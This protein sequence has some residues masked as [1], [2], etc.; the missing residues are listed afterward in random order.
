MVTRKRLTAGDDEA[1]FGSCEAGSVNGDRARLYP[2][3]C[4]WLEDVQRDNV[5]RVM[6]FEKAKVYWNERREIEHRMMMVLSRSSSK[7]KRAR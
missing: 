1:F 4:H 6:C 5:K 7:R 2:G 3:N